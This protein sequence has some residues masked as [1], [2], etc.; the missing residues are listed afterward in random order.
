MNIIII[1]F[2]Y[3]YIYKYVKKCG[4]HLLYWNWVK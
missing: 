2:F 1:I 4:Q 3:K